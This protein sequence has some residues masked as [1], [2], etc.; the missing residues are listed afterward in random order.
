ME[1]LPRNRFRTHSESLVLRAGMCSRAPRSF[2]INNERYYDAIKVFNW[3]RQYFHE[4]KTGRIRN[5]IKE[6][7][8]DHN[9]YIFAYKKDNNWI[10]SNNKYP[11]AKLLLTKKWVC[12]YVSKF[13]DIQ[14]DTM[15]DTATQELNI[16]ETIISKPTTIKINGKIYY[17]A[18]ELKE[19]D[20]LYFHGCAKTVRKIIDKKNISEDQYIYITYNNSK[21]EYTIYK[22]TEKLSK[23]AKL[24]LRKKWV[25][26]NI[27][28]MSD[29]NKIKYDI[30]EL[31]QKLE[32]EDHEKF[33]D[34][35]GNVLEIE[36]YGERDHKKCYFKAKDIANIFKMPNLVKNI[37]DKNT[38]YVEN[39]DYKFFINTNT[40]ELCNRTKETYL[41]YNGILCALYGSHS[42]TARS[43]REWA[44][45]TLFTIQLGTQ[46]NKKI[47]IKTIGLD[48]EDM[49]SYIKTSVSKLSCIY[50]LNL[51][52]VKDLR[53]TFKIKQKIKDDYIIC[54][55]G[56]T[57][58]L[59]R[60]L[61]EHEKDYGK[62]E[63]VN[64]TVLKYAYIDPNLITDAE[65]SVSHMFNITE[66]KL[67]VDK[68]KELIFINPKNIKYVEE[69]FESLQ[70]R[71]AGDYREQ[72]YELDKWKSKYEVLQKDLELQ[73]MK[74]SN[75]EETNK[76][77]IELLELKLSIKN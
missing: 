39:E 2:I 68:R 44:T 18:N 36:V 62:I 10:I 27:P 16:H 47:L 71:Y 70:K 35:D 41:T 43:F 6:K 24:M 19:Y 42:Q 15:S 54:K 8:L 45:C 75:L 51:G 49:K 48:I 57:N 23:T 60:R 66:N 76:L 77:K 72:I 25:L 74:Y 11:K 3:D 59:D 55:F 53:E 14:S 22:D 67:T 46:E 37:Y 63:N 7:K 17:D 1:D 12:S 4:N 64:L 32:L 58:D 21:Q 20:K 31:S 61:T 29:N 34:N 26:K 38:R 69:Y 73:K 13:I 30:D 9:N 65:V 28:K 5:I 40:Q 52:Y 56:K 33:K 50:L